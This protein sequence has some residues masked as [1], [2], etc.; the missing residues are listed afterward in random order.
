MEEAGAK[1]SERYEVIHDYNFWSWGRK[2]PGTFVPGSES[3]RQLS[4]A[5]AKVPRMEL[6]LQ[7]VKVLRSES[8]IIPGRRG[9]C[10]CEI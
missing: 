5:G 2:F 1:F 10:C 7:G 4:P 9:C 8:S 3:S 6:S